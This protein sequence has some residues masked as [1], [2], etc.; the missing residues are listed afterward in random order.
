MVHFP[1]LAALAVVVRGNH[2]LLVKRINEPDAGL[3]G[4]PGGHVDEGETALEAAVRELKEE[5]G[6]VGRAL[7]YL[8]NVDLIEKNADGSIRFHFLLAAVQ[9]EYERGEPTAND[10][11]S[12]SKWCPIGHVLGGEI[13][14]SEHVDTV[15]RVARHDRSN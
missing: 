12:A 1:K 8:T 5:T 9:C 2:V 15:L 14:C 7:K 4:F 6:I 3:W 11:V 10:D 13:K